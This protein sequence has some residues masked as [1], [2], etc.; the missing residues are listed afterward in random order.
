MIGIKL[1]GENL[2]TVYSPAPAAGFL[3][4]EPYLVPAEGKLSDEYVELWE[5]HRGF[6]A[7]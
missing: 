7:L 2:I 5:R 6:T 3:E 4:N 1:E